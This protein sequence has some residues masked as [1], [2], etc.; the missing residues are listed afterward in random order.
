M[1]GWRI[2]KKANPNWYPHF[3]RFNR[4]SKFCE[5]PEVTIQQLLSWFGWT[6][7]RT[8]INYISKGRKYVRQLSK[9][10]ESEISDK[11]QTL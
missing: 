7:M 4:A 5:D 3:F 8:P 9:K 6:D 2:V 10:L 11:T 1:T